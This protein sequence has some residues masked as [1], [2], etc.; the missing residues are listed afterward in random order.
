MSK[1]KLI[2]ESW[3][4]FLTESDRGYRTT[5]PDGNDVYLRH[6]KTLGPTGESN[7]AYIIYN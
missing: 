7:Q 3:R 1:H 4:K 5:T 6:E 2:M